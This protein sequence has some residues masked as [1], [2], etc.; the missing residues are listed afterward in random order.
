MAHSVSFSPPLSVRGEVRELTHAVPTALDVR[1][2]ASADRQ[3][4]REVQALETLS[5]VNAFYRAVGKPLF[6]HIIAPLLLV[7]LAPILLVIAI[8]VR[9]TL[10]KGVLFMQERV[11]RGG[12]P[13]S[14]LKFRTMRPDRRRRQVPMSSADRRTC[15]KRA[16]DPRH[17]P[18]GRF[19]RRRSLDELPQLVNV[20]H[21]EMSLV[22]PRPELPS[23]V[24]TYEPWQHL[25]H[26]VKPGITGPWQVTARNDGALLQD[27]TDL[28]VA[29]AR[30]VS[31][32]YD[33]ELALA[34][35][36]VVGDSDRGGT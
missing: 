26:L 7:A 24:R 25:R 22:G 35:F 32:R 33:L 12:V 5:W 29:Y 23:V 13:F 19:L 2:L 34:T 3:V 16:D 6:D 36:R 9:V 1:G 30:N 18:L 21:G 31:F 14:M 27:C 17:T 10:G 4:L 28:D 11:G 20:M 8:A 15:H